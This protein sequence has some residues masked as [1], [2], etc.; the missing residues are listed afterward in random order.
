[1]IDPG[2]RRF[3]IAAVALGFAAFVLAYEQYALSSQEVRT[4]QYGRFVCIPLWHMDEPTATEELK[5]ILKTREYRSIAIFLEDDELFTRVDSDPEGIGDRLMSTLALVRDRRIV[6]PLEY[7]GTPLGRIEATWVN[8]SIYI[9]L[10]VAF[11]LALVAKIAQYYRHLA[12]SRSELEHRVRERTTELSRTV[13]DLQEQVAERKSAE[14][15]LQRSLEQN[16]VLVKEVHHRVKNN[17][18]VISSMLA[19]QTRGMRDEAVQTALRESN[20]RIQLMAR[21]HE[22]LYSSSD[23]ARVD[24]A[25]Y[26]E[27]LTKNVLK[28]YGADEEKISLEIAVA[29]VTLGVDKAI[30]CSMIVNELVSNSLKYA[31]PA[32]VGEISVGLIAGPNH[33][34]TL[35]VA[36]DGTGLPEGVDFRTTRSLGMQLVCSFAKQLKGEIDLV[37]GPGTRFEVVFPR[38]PEEAEAA[39]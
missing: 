20:A 35:S 1:M 28:A 26:V 36:D 27:D 8:R 21:V 31:F 10:Y 9:Y 33:H 25:E 34:L 15:R 7:R 22:Q 37:K 18:Q 16:E 3:W 2:G 24:F 19:L 6:R 32:G 23:L 12:H 39:G 5:L 4:D 14:E 30:P 38:G 11:S 29:S 17:L 13:T